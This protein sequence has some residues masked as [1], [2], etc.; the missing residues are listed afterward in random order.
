MSHVASLSTQV[1]VTPLTSSENVRMAYAG[2]VKE[3]APPSKPIAIPAV[4][5]KLFTLSSLYWDF[6]QNVDNPQL[7]R[8]IFMPH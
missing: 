5:V 7:C 6:R 1:K 8:A 3:S 4:Y 2:E